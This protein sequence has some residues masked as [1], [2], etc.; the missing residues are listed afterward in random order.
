MSSLEF[1]DLPDSWASTTLDDVVKHG[2]GRK[3]PQDHPE[4]PYLGL[5]HIEEGTMKLSGKA[6][7][8]EYNS[9]S[10]Y[11]QPGDILYGRLRPYLNK[12]YTATF[13]GLGSGELIVLIPSNRVY[14]RYLSYVLNSQ[15]FVRHANHLSTGDRPRVNYNKIKDFE[16]PLPPVEEQKRIVNKIEELLSKLESGVSELENT[17]ETLNQYKRSVLQNAVEGHITGDWRKNQEGLESADELLQRTADVREKKC[18]GKYG[19]L[20]EPD[21]IPTDISIPSD[22]TW[23]SLSQ[24][25]EVSRGKSTHRPRDDPSLFG[26][27]YPFIQTGDVRAASTELNNYEKTYNEE[28]LDQSRLWPKKTL[29]ITI[30][31]NIGETAVLGIEACFPDSVVGFL[32]DPEYCNVYYIEL[33]FRTIQRDLERYA[34]ATAQK[35]INLGTL[36]D[37]PVPLPPIEEQNEI[38]QRTH[39]KMSIINNNMETISD[40]LIRAD[41]LRK[42]VLNYALQGKLVPQDDNKAAAGHPYENSTTENSGSQLDGQMKL[43]EVINDVE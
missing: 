23:T 1:S 30:A 35:N 14:S 29:C 2:R 4:L 27:E 18:G 26:G 38:V 33:Y 43:T 3:D 40:E 42:S 32:T 12:V 6:K 41:R 10:V 16:I 34:P 31:A 21:D 25:G 17:E 24:I 15:S 37:L 13:E 39:A 28:G 9:S 8:D 22:W 20:A 11:F 7:A 19:K 5:K 36:T